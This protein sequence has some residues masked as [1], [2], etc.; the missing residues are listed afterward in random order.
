MF[1]AFSCTKDGRLQG[2][3]REEGKESCIRFFLFLKGKGDQ[4]KTHI[5]NH[6][7]LILCDP[8]SSLNHRFGFNPLSR[9]S[10]KK[11][12]A[13]RKPDPLNHCH[14]GPDPCPHGSVFSIEM[15][16]LRPTVP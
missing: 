7:C 16:A 14:R 5:A 9:V 4:K 2:N 12:E 11:E 6:L 3:E 13:G 15:H 10:N 8:L 1:F